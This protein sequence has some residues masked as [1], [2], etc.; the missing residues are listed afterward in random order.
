MNYRI[1]EVAKITGTSKEAIRYLE[2]MNC[3][4]E[5]ARN[6]SGYR[7]YDPLQM[8]FYAGSGRAAAMATQ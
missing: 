4:N 1:G 3:I 6:A 5:P 8:G 2:K 7:E